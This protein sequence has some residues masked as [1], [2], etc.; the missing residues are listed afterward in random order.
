[1]SITAPILT[2]KAH[3]DHITQIQYIKTNDKVVSASL[4]GK[5]CL[6]D[7]VTKT[8]DYFHGHSKPVL[9]VCFVSAYSYMASSGQEREIQIWSPYTQKRITSLVGHTAA[10]KSMVFN[11]T[12]SHF[13]TMSVDK[14]VIVWDPKTYERLCTVQDTQHVYR[15]EDTFTCMAWDDK[16][17]RLILAHSRLQLWPYK[18]DTKEGWG[19]VLHTETVLNVLYNDMFKTI[20]TVDVSGL[21]ILWKSDSGQQHT[22][23]SIKHDQNERVCAA[24]FDR[25]QRRLIVGTSKGRVWLYNWNSGVRLN[26]LESD[27]DSDVSCVLNTLSTLKANEV[28][29]GHTVATGWNRLVRLEMISLLLFLLHWITS[30]CDIMFLGKSQVYI[31]NDPPD[32]YTLAPIK[33]IDL[34]CE[35]D[36]RTMTWM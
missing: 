32:T 15:P 31:W 16:T 29:R 27:M 24:E 30:M 12:H 18:G 28:A 19:L 5:I 25:S 35:C 4:D 17:K 14:Q 34:Q 2:V 10:V 20:V 33:R 21:V 11:P 23:W 3:S 8:C 22:A 1:M 26:D 6:I 13:I 7:L 36:V 9:C